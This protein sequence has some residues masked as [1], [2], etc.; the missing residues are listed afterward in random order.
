MHGMNWIDL[1]EVGEFVL[2]GKVIKF[3]FHKTLENSRLAAQ[4]AAS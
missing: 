1:V 3:G 2:V 4:L